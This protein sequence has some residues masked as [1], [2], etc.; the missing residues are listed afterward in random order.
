[1]HPF[2][3]VF[4]GWFNYLPC[5]LFSRKKKKKKRKITPLSS[6]LQ[7][8][9]Q[10]VIFFHK[11]MKNKNVVLK[12]VCIGEDVGL[13]LR[14]GRRLKQVCEG[15]FLDQVVQGWRELGVHTWHEKSSKKFPKVPL[16]P[17]LWW[18]CPN[19]KKKEEKR[20]KEKGWDKFYMEKGNCG[21]M[22]FPLG[23]H[24]WI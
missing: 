10:I 19:E 1:M 24:E 5:T 8:F 9:C 7:F 4:F 23:T 22:F 20:K 2:F 13:Q 21:S 16:G 12:Q 3:Q 15:N 14:L 18:S 17:L 11:H 6:K